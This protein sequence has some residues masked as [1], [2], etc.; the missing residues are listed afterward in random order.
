MEHYW[1]D[2]TPDTFRAIVERLRVAMDD[3]AR[4]GAEVRLLHSTF[5][6]V[7]ESALCVF[8]C[9]G[10]EDVEEAYRRAGVNFERILSVLEIEIGKPAAPPTTGGQQQ[11][12]P[13]P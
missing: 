13:F 11:G 7:D 8:L 10:Q 9:S 4:S 3:M 12:V 1:P 2:A 5:V 6:P